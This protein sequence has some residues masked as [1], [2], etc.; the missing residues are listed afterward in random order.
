MFQRISKQFDEVDNSN[1]FISCFTLVLLVNILYMMDISRVFLLIVMVSTSGLLLIKLKFSQLLSLEIV[2]KSVLLVKLS[3]YSLLIFI[4]TKVV[5]L[6]LNFSIFYAIT[7]V[8]DVI[9]IVCCLVFALFYSLNNLKWSNISNSIKLSHTL[10]LI[11][12]VIVNQDSN[13][14]FGIFNN[15]N[16][17]AIVTSLLAV[18]SLNDSLESVYSKNKNSFLINSVLFFISIFY[19]LET[20]SRTAILVIGFISVILLGRFITKAIYMKKSKWIISLFVITIVLSISSMIIPQFSSLIK[21][22][23]GKFIEK[24]SNGNILDGRQDIWNVV[25][26][27]SK[28]FG[29]G[30]YYFQNTTFPNIPVFAPHNTFVSILG[31]SG[32]ASMISFFSY[33]FVIV[34]KIVC[35]SIK[36]KTFNF[37]VIVLL[38]FF[39][40]YSI[41]ESML[42]RPIMIISQLIIFIIPLK[43]IESE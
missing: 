43:N 39:L 3:I 29:S 24:M 26:K 25:F 40:L 17:T 21:S 6:M 37:V 18:V 23:S 36:T 27:Q 9:V 35:N 8:S 11:S 20:H 19:T 28:L 16:T 2:F 41:P 42:Y 34:P 4:F 13:R 38:L 5:S 15:Y 7:I 32:I 1:L 22:T 33:C 30:V 14:F 12:S 31:I 10:I